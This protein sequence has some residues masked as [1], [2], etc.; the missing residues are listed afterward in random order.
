MFALWSIGR[1]LSAAQPL[2]FRLRSHEPRI[3]EQRAELAPLRLVLQTKREAQLAEGQEMARGARPIRRLRGVAAFAFDPRNAERTMKMKRT[4]LASTCAAA[5]TLSMTLAA[6]PLA[7]AQEQGASP[8]QRETSGHQTKEMRPAAHPRQPMDQ[9]KERS[10]AAEERPQPDAPAEMKKKD[11][12]E[13]EKPDVSTNRK[14]AEEREQSQEK[15]MQSSQ[16]KRQDMSE[17]E[18]RSGEAAEQ[19]RPEK[20]ADE[21]AQE[22]PEHKGPND[23]EA[24]GQGRMKLDQ[25]QASDLR[26]RLEKRGGEKAAGSAAFSVRVGGRV[27]Q[28]VRLLEAPGDTV[29]EYPQFRGYDY[30]VEGDEII[31]VDPRTR[32]VVEIVGSPEY[33]AAAEACHERLRL[34]REQNEV[35]RRNIHI[36]PSATVDFDEDRDE[37]V[38]DTFVLLPLPGPVVAEIPD[39]SHYQYFVDRNGHIVLVDP[40]THEVVDVVD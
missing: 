38:P 40:A 4:I 10:S 17:P 8:Q 29:E 14:A 34:S 3:K 16:T 33:R 5:L 15:K 9:S 2:S 25:R 20:G 11:A 1:H 6:S 39:A 18:K 37:R 32:E 26:S 36:D 24:A 23:R 35:I 12:S 30:V 19:R 27:P 22:R 13:S 28:G 7:F 21:S 31:F